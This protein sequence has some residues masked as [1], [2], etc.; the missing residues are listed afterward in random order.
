MQPLN[1]RIA[2]ARAFAGECQAHM[3][4]LFAANAAEQADL[5][6][7]AAVFRFTAAQEKAHAKIFYDFLSQG[8]DKSI[9]FEADYPIDTVT[10][11]KALLLQAYEHET[12]EFDPVYPSFAVVARTENA[13]PVAHAFEQIAKVEKT[14]ADRFLRIARAMEDNRLFIADRETTFVCLNCG[15]IMQTQNAPLRCPVCDHPRGYIVRHDLA[16]YL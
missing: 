1:T 10:D 4:Y 12:K 2:L 6:A 9:G 7:V 13:L 11:V 15:H 16:P 5:H 14:H 3:Q 8:T